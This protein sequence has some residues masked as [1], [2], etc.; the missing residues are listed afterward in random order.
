M[1]GH[2]PVQECAAAG[3]VVAFILGQTVD[4]RH[5]QRRESA[6]KTCRGASGQ[7]Q[8]QPVS[9]PL[10][11]MIADPRTEGDGQTVLGLLDLCR[12]IQTQRFKVSA[13]V[14]GGHHK[15]NR[16]ARRQQ[17]HPVTF[18][19]HSGQRLEQHA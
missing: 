6:G 10:A 14:G 13:K 12:R 16:I 5:G 4:F 2:D 1:G 7:D 19:L 17:G 9:H 15:I 8:L 11:R 18:G 3:P